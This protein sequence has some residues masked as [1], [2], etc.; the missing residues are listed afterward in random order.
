MKV[1]KPRRDKLII[2]VTAAAV[3]VLII[4]LLL[5]GNAK[6]PVVDEELPLPVSEPSPVVSVDP[7]P[8]PPPKSLAEEFAGLWGKIDGSTATIPLTA[9]LF[10]KLADNG[11]APVHN[12]TPMAYRYL[13]EGTADL[14]FVTYP[15]EEELSKMEAQGIE[16]EIIPVAKDALVFLVNIENPVENVSLSQLREIYMGEIKSWDAVGGEKEDIIPYQRSLNSGSQTLMLKLLMNGREPMEPLGELVHGDMGGLVDAISTYDNSRPAL[17]YSMFY[18]VNNMY[19][20]SR[21]KLLSI[22][23]VKPS[24]ESIMNDEYPLVDGYYAV[25]RKDMPEYSPAR[26]LIDWFLTDEGQRLASGAGY[27][28]LR[29][30]AGETSGSEIDPIYVGDYVNSSGTGGTVWKGWEAR[31]EI[32]ENGVKKPLSYLFYDDFNYIEYINSKLFVELQSM[33]TWFRFPTDELVLKRSFPGI[34]NDYPH[35]ELSEWSPGITIEFPADNPYFDDYRSSREFYIRLNKYISPFGGVA[36]DYSVSYKRAGLLMPNVNFVTASVDIPDFPNVTRQINHSLQAWVDGFLLD[37]EKANLI[38]SYEKENHIG[39]AGTYLFAPVSGVWENYLCVS[40]FLGLGEG[41]GHAHWFPLVYSICFDMNTGATVNLADKIPKNIDF[42]KAFRVNEAP[43]MDG[44]M[45][46][47]KEGYLPAEGSRISNV[48]VDS[49][50]V[51]YVTEPDG[52]ELQYIFVDDDF[53]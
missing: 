50:N 49:Y 10:D 37:T 40:Y 11:R 43:N 36:P 5:I 22:D 20:N 34:P 6:P 46:P 17:G 27:I 23:G 41:G 30:I 25:I 53:T 51:I 39:Y 31:E 33:D 42:S 45:E 13:I 19:G 21:F 48:L 24:R 3:L 8:P 18:Y 4:A 32:V 52:R 28:P 35:Y 29:P 7:P 9:A 1:L 38:E 44:G 12:T 14:I 2:I 26:L 16:F 47:V 15:S